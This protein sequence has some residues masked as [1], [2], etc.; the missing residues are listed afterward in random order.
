MSTVSHANSVCRNVLMVY[1]ACLPATCMVG[2]Y[3]AVGIVD[4]RVRSRVSG[5][6]A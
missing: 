5:V 3:V 1:M 4:Y 2:L 6:D